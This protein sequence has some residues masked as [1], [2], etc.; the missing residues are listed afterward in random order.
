MSVN[1][2][3]LQQGDFHKWKLAERTDE[4]NNIMSW[5]MFEDNN[6]T[7]SSFHNIKYWNDL[8][9]KT[10]NGVQQNVNNGLPP[11]EMSSYLVNALTACKKRVLKCGL[12]T[13]YENNCENLYP[14]IEFFEDFQFDMASLSR[15]LNM[16]EGLDRIVTAHVNRGTFIYSFNSEKKNE[17]GVDVLRHMMKNL[18]PHVY[19]F[20]SGD[21]SPKVFHKEIVD[22][23]FTEYA[24]GDW[25]DFEDHK[26]MLVLMSNALVVLRCQHLVAVKLSIEVLKRFVEWYEN[27][28]N[29]K[30]KVEKQKAEEKEAAVVDEVFAGIQDAFKKL[31]AKQRQQLF[32]R[33]VGEQGSS[34]R[35][36][37]IAQQ[38]T[39]L[40]Q[41]EMQNGSSSSQVNGNMMNTT[42]TTTT[43]T[44]KTAKSPPPQENNKN[45]A[46]TSVPSRSNSVV[47]NVDANEMDYAVAIGQKVKLSPLG[48]DKFD[49]DNR[50]KPF[51]HHRDNI[52]TIVKIMQPNMMK[53]M[54]RMYELKSVIADQEFLY[55]THGTDISVIK[56][57]DDGKQTINEFMHETKT[58]MEHPWEHYMYESIAQ[59]RDCTLE[60]LPTSAEEWKKVVKLK[61]ETW[62]DVFNEVNSHNGDIEYEN[63][64]LMYTAVQF[65]NDESEVKKKYIVI[66]CE[67]KS[68]QLLAVDPLNIQFWCIRGGKR[69]YDFK[70][71]EIEAYG[72]KKKGQRKKV[73]ARKNG[74]T[75]GKTAAMI[76]EAKK[77]AS[78]GNRKKKRKLRSGRQNL[79]NATPKTPTSQ[80][81]PKRGCVGKGVNRLGPGQSGVEQI[82]LVSDEDESS[83]SDD[84][85]GEEKSSDEEENDSDLN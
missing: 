59:M 61:S 25:D 30:L 46:F 14:T 71:T 22:Q 57:L 50:T 26:Q 49:K 79:L 41:I 37:Q 83:S 40:Q 81:R 39:A 15:V 47:L 10:V 66:S 78:T 75:G 69:V 23:K 27:A 56:D 85:E 38:N 63:D 29:D 54:I 28:I 35:E 7:A 33:M 5:K 43:T 1:C 44:T 32:A 34:I 77:N 64:T 80:G 52:F 21:G 45:S 20:M 72:T 31:S 12:G 2:P 18:Y 74:G 53:E 55:T 82:N 62:E 9:V 3:K 24:E 36:K 84:D 51:M 68:V 4:E 58:K 70:V 48:L 67:E 6:V 76:A 16:N 19:N 73:V 8:W 60:E 11:N 13:K 65:K 17:L 42:T